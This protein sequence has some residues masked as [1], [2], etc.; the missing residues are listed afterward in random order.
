MPSKVRTSRDVIALTVLAL[1]TERPLHPYEM[2][3]LMRERHKDFAIG[4]A[5]SFYD[6]VNR[7]L[8]DGLIEALETSR[9]GKRPERTTYR[10]TDEGREELGSW[11]DELLSTP[12]VEYP[13]FTVAMNFLACLSPAAAVQALQERVINLEGA[14]AGLDGV[15][16]VLREQ[17]GLPRLVLLEHEH[18]QALRKAELE[19]VRS[20]I[21]DIQAGRLSWDVYLDWSR[22]G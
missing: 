20:I 13:L 21:A 3:R 1:L 5:R 2:Q 17:A 12:A 16:R 19:W 10:I 15:M 9:E 7:L 18:T 4:K 8:R 11:L 22:Q 6:A 14:L